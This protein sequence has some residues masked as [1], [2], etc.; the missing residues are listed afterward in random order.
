MLARWFYPLLPP[1]GRVLDL[2][3]GAGHVTQLVARQGFSIIG[4]D[5]SDEML[6]YAQQRVP[7]GEFWAADARAFVLD[8]PVNGVLST[9]DSLNHIMSAGD[10]EQVF[11][12]VRSALVPGG[13]FF[14]DMNADAAYN[15]PWT[16][17]GS[18]NDRNRHWVAHGAYDAA[19]RMAACEVEETWRS[20][21]QSP[22]QRRTFH[23]NQRCY[24]VDEVRQAL[25][26]AGFMTIEVHTSPEVGLA[27]PTGDGRMFYSVTR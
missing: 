4:I 17:I 7:E 24:N 2:C 6:R 9:Y 12:H 8:R 19:T 21:A 5:G 14:F 22:W 16:Y 25:R 10:L 27:G 26:A 20:D 3:C 23:L 1:G 13:L 11:A 18:T 15:E